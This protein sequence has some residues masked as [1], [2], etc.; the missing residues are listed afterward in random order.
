MATNNFKKKLKKEQ[1]RTFTARDFESIR[2]QLL[3]T[4]RTYFPNKIQDFSEASVGG[5]FLDFVAT[6][7]DSLSFYLDHAFREL[8]P[9][10][11]V[12]PENIL[13]HLRNAGVNI[14]GA[15]PASVELQ[16][17]MTVPA[18]FLLSKKSF[19]PKRSALPVILAGTAASSFSGTSFATVDDLDFAE[20]DEDGNFLADFVILSTND[21]G[22]PTFFKVSRTVTAVSGIITNE[23]ISI[24]NAFVPFR[25]I[26]LAE[27]SITAILSIMDAESNTYYEVTSLSEDT[28]FLK[29]K[30]KSADLPKVPHHIKLIPAPYRFQKRYDPTTQ[31]TTI[32]FGGGKC[33]DFG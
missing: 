8:D 11:A 5:M 28:V 22:Q 31:L 18:E 4:A 23:T 30:N 29:V 33:G 6:V 26:T 3:D 10:R 21:L 7:G 17:T 9:I 24:G 16:F 25:E 12:E 13:M 14:V 15:S 19:L 20:Q 2:S 1:N 27:K 32:R